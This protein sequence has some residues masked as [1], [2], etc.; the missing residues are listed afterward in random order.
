[1]ERLFSVDVLDFVSELVLIISSAA[2]EVRRHFGAFRCLD[3]VLL[4]SV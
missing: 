1:M 2:K 4:N 3:F